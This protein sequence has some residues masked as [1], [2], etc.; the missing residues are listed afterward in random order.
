MGDRSVL[1]SG[2]SI[3]GPVAAYWLAKAGFTPTIVERA[4]APRPGGQAIDVRGAALD[5]LDRMN[6]LEAARGVKT[7]MKGFSTIDAEGKELWR[8]EEMTLSGGAFDND[9][10]E[11]LRDDLAALL[12]GALPTGTEVIYGDHITALDED[13]DGVTV[14]FAR[15]APRRFGLVIGA[16][17]VNSGVRDLVFGD[18]RQFLQSLDIALAIY[19]APNDIGLADWQASH[20]SGQA[21]CIVYTVHDNA[22]LRLCYSFPCTLDEERRGDVEG[23]KALLADKAAGLGWVVPHLLEA[24]GLAQD[25]W[26]GVIAQVRMPRWSKGRIAL[27]GDAGYS[28]S[29][30][31]GQG[32][33]LALV[34][35]YV[36]AQE[37]GRSAG[38]HAPLDHAG[39]FAR[40]EARMRPFVDKNQELI[41][42]SKKAGF[43]EA[44]L[45][46]A[47]FEAL[48]SAKAAI[49]LDAGG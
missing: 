34:G 42:V 27:A 29:P 21:G 11:V 41:E 32:T 33:S 37:L 17:G 12:M 28:P 22:E 40:Y 25:F 9:D 47:M 13:A 1:I 8:T 19:S 36:L 45:Q 39:A 24:V 2:A 3:A 5:V 44:G 10:I 16:D 4:P 49:D 43:S 7:Q 46:N 38:D 31:S 20:R 18:E 6:L 30:A 23:Q 26:L 15:R 35:A 14:S 48:E